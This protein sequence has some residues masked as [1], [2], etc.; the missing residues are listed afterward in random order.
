MVIPNASRD[1]GKW[2]RSF[3]AGEMQMVDILEE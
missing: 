3:T 2:E 1:V